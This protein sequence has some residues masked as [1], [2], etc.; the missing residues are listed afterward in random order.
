M[1]AIRL[2]LTT[3]VFGIATT[4]ALANELPASTELARFGLKMA[5]WGRAAVDPGREKVDFVV[6]DEELVF[7]RS[8]AGIITAFDAETGRKAWSA[9]SRK[10]ASVWPPSLLGSFR[11]STHSA[12][13][14]ARPPRLPQE[15]PPK[16][17]CRCRAAQQEEFGCGVP[18]RERAR[19]RHAA[20]P[21]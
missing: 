9:H 2:F 8:T 5:W 3:C 21:L 20:A 17:S 18:N 6:N 11:S 12:Q 19:G 15:L 7:V 16:S 13:R 1:Q 10:P 4:A 14:R